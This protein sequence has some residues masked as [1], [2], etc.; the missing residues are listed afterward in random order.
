VVKGKE[1]KAGT[2]SSDSTWTRSQRTKKDLQTF[3]SH[4][5]KPEIA[6]TFDKKVLRDIPLVDRHSDRG[7]CRDS[8]THLLPL[9][10]EERFEKLRRFGSYGT[11][12]TRL[13]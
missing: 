9:S 8:M 10:E 12:A 1:S 6:D 3:F 4:V 5:L 13:D 2:S 11:H 7:L